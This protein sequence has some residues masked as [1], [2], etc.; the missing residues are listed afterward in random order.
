MRPRDGR[1]VP[2]MIVQALKEQPLTV[3][4]DG[5][6]TRSFCF[7]SDL[8]AGI[9]ALAESNQHDPV[10][11]GNPQEMTVLAFAEKARA[12]CGSSSEIVHTPLPVDDPKVRQPNIGRARDLLGWSPKVDIDEGL[13][14][15]VEYFQALIA[16]GRV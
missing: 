13:A 2:T 11:I 7:V 16:E 8:I 5:S 12:L 15:T 14:R 3:F 1:V 9:Y 6:Q 4:G 10:N